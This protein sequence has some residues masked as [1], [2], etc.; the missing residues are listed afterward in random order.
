MSFSRKGSFIESSEGFSIEEL[1]RE[2]IR[3]HE[4]SHALYVWTEFL[5]PQG[6][7]VSTRGMTRWDPPNDQELIDPTQKE[8]ILHNIKEAIEYEGETVTFVS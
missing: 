2:G 6:T 5:M 4:R 3:Y 8:R 7:A 1:G